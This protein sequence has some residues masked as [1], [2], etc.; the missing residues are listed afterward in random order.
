M[1]WTTGS[2]QLMRQLVICSFGPF[3]HQKDIEIL[4]KLQQKS[5]RKF[6]PVALAL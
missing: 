5:P 3:Q 2:Q 4:E 6:E 1:G